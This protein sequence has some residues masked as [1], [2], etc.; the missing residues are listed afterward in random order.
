M[1]L[2]I[3]SNLVQTCVV[4]RGSET[5]LSV[6]CATRQHMYS[7]RVSFLKSTKDWCTNRIQKSGVSSYFCI[8][9]TEVSV[10]IIDR[11]TAKITNSSPI[12]VTHSEHIHEVTI[13]TR[14]FWQYHKVQKVSPFCLSR[15]TP[16]FCLQPEWKFFIAV[17]Q[18][19][20]VRKRHVCVI[21]PLQMRGCYSSVMHKYQN[22]WMIVAKKEFF[23]S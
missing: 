23:I 17:L 20:M 2:R 5:W 21:A 8:A 22:F 10:S 7:S 12:I 1:S 14:S 15:L 19:A 18:V 4:V 3:L 13:Q 16:V 6:I 9:S 11:E